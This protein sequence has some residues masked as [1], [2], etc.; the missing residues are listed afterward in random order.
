LHVATREAAEDVVQETF[1]GVIEGIDRF[2]A[3]SSL[4]TWMFRILTNVAKG[5][6]QREARTRPFSSFEA[7]LEADEPTVDPDR[8]IASGRWAGYWAAPPVEYDVPGARVLAAE[9][10][11]R[12]VNAIE[13]LPP[14]QR[15]VI[16]LRDVKGLSASEVCQLLDISES[17]QRVLLHRARTKTRAS[18]E[19]YLDERV[20]VS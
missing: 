12:L 10:G 19:C 18:L 20:E 8:F 15:T 7:E 5:R 11:D 2:E 9:A 16:T 4:R 14:S 1:L 17:N 13:A 6:G 3:R